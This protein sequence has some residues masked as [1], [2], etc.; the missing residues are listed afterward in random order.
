MGHS[1]PEE[2]KKEIVEIC[3]RFNVPI[4][5]DDINGDFALYGK[6]GSNLKKYDKDGNVIHISSFSKTLSS[7]MRIGWLEAGRYFDSII[8]Q[9]I[10]CSLSSNEI[11]QYTIA[12]YLASGKYPRHLRRLNNSI[13]NHMEAYSLKILKYFPE[14][15][16]LSVPQGGFVLWVELPEQVD[17]NEIF[18]LALKKKISF[19]P[20]SIF[21]S[22]EKYSNCMRINCG[23]PMDDRMEKGIATLGELC[24]SYI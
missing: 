4:I 14:G 2:V 21:T 15:T 10:A 9:K 7:G 24:K 23:F 12:N 13:R 6:R 17:T 19:S 5:E 22:Q 1:Y 8:K 3:S 18:P 11:S 20:G 16:K